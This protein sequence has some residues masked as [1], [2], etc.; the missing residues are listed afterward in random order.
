MNEAIVASARRWIGTPYCHQAST[1]GAGC[2][3]LGLVRGV[4][5]DVIGPEPE[6]IPRYTQDWT[7]KGSNKGPVSDPLWEMC[8]RQFVPAS[9]NLEVGNV[10][11]F[12]MRF[13]ASAKHLGIISEIGR[14]VRFIH[15]YSR[16][17][18]I[19]Q[20]LTHS[21]ERRIMASFSFPALTV[22]NAEAIL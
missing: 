2:D 4:W 17:G 16:H 20:K 14:Q 18:V 12:Q 8:M 3:C 11:L 9:K 5:R 19:E 13:G 7:S 1:K 15:S 6:A 21:W 10:V 22:L